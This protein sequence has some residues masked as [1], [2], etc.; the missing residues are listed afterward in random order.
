V[1]NNI[2][3]H[4]EVKT[5]KTLNLQEAWRQSVKTAGLHTTPYVVV[6]FDGMALDKWLVVMDNHDWLEL[7]QKAQ[8][9]K[10][11]ESLTGSR[12]LRYK[13]QSAINA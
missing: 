1:G 4:F 7:W 10:T 12:E 2:D 5:V 6:H 11:R 9:P 3:I 13:T 8:E